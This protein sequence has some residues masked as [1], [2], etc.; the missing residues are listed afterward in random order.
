MQFPGCSLTQEQ[1]RTWSLYESIKANSATINSL[2]PR[3]ALSVKLSAMT[4]CAVN[5]T[6]VSSI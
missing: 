1:T 5:V 3:A 2:K 4:T 6:G